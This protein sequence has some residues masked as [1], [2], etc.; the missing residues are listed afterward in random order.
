MRSSQEWRI[1]NEQEKTRVLIVEDDPLVSRMV[2]GLLEEIGYTVG[3]TVSDGRQA[4]EVIQ[5]IRPD[6]VL[7]DIKMS[8]LNG[9]EVARLIQERCPTP[10]VVLSAY[11]TPELLKMASDA[12]AGAYLVKPPNAREL[13]RAISISISRFDDMMSLRRQAAEL[14][15]LRQASLRL[16]SRLE[17]QSVLAALLE[18]VIKLVDAYDTHIFFYDGDQISF[19]AALWANGTQGQPFASPRPDGLTYAVARAG[20]PIVIENVNTHP[21]FQSWRWGGAIAGL[22]LR[23]GEQV[24]GVMNVAYQEPHPFDENELRLLEL[25][26]AQAAIAIHNARLFEQV[27]RHA[28]EL[29]QAVRERTR[30]LIEANEQLTELDRLK[31]R[32]IADISHELRTPATNVRLYLDL[33]KHGKPGKQDQYLKVIEEQTDQLVRLI[34]DI[35]SFSRLELNQSDT[36]F[37]MVDLNLIAEQVVAANQTRAD[38]AN[39]KLTFEPDTALPRVRGEPTQLAQA[40]SELLENAL[41]YTQVGQVRVTTGV[42]TERSQVCLEVA[43]T[44]RGIEAEDLAHLFDRFYRGRGVGSSNLPG[45]GLGL[46][47]AQDIVEL[48][49]GQ[50]KV[51]SQVGEGSTFRL[52]LP[53]EENQA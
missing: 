6:V 53:L 25:L 3:G 26:A 16:T 19:G 27:Q 20:Q 48:H 4:L 30:E 29:E 21:L 43:D 50:I 5:S 33:L 36:E 13:E 52:Y 10:V 28:D 2:Q 32:F 11:E 9:I 7:M 18:Q 37:G 34:E 38:A 31:S 47:I 40:V 8:D 22:P 35:L 23:V 14:E 1:M 51:E 49:K 17:L 12:G 45:S 42:V 44:G 39:L 15:A 24:I 41:D 46:S